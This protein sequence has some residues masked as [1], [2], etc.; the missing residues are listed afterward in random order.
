MSH[1]DRAIANIEG[2]DLCTGE[3]EWD[4]DAAMS[5]SGSDDDD[6]GDGSDSVSGGD[7]ITQPL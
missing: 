5:D 2:G 7:L 4:S 3:I 6:E 1:A